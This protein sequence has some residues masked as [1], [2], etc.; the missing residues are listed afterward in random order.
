MLSQFLTELSAT[1]GVSEEVQCIRN[2][3]IWRPAGGETARLDVAG[4]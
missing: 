3:D 4:L 2:N 1:T